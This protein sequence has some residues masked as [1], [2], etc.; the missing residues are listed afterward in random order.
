MTMN[1]VLLAYYY[2]NTQVILLTFIIILIFVFL[3][4][5]FYS[6]NPIFSIL[7][8]MSTFCLVAFLLIFLGIEF[9]SLLFLVVYVGAISIL[10]LFVI[11]MIDL[12]LLFMSSTKKYFLANF[13]NILLFF[14]FFLLFFFYKFDTIFYLY[15]KNLYFVDWSLLSNF[16]TDIQQTGYILYNFF[17]FDFIITGLIL[18][19]AMVGCIAL[20]LENNFITK[21]QNLIAQMLKFSKSRYKLLISTGTTSILKLI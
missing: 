5:L 12:K 21:K 13:I 3:F 2:L 20:V 9:L 15:K 16:K 19:C 8:L 18:F 6:N 14:I 4:L 7:C 11:M 1:L 17:Y 10:F